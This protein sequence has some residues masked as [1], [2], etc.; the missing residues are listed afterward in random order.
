VPV[1]VRRERGAL[2]FASVP[3]SAVPLPLVAICSN[4]RLQRERL[5][6]SVAKLQRP[7]TRS[8]VFANATLVVDKTVDTRCSDR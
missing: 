5:T 6:A 2:Q 8:S 4:C 1:I 7:L 3:V